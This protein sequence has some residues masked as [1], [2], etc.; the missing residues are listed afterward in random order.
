MYNPFD[1]NIDELI[2]DD[3]YSLVENQVKEGFYVEFKSDFQKNKDIAKS[4]ASFANTRGGWY[5]IGVEDYDKTN[6]AKDIVGFD[7]KKH[8]Q[9]KESIRQIVRTNIHPIPFFEMEL[10]ESNDDKYVLVIFIPES[11]ETPHILSNGVIYLRNGEESS[12]IEISDKYTLDKLYQKNSFLEAKLNS[13]LKNPFGSPFDEKNAKLPF[14]NLC[15]LPKNFN[16]VEIKDFYDKLFLD[17]FREMINQNESLFSDNQNITFNINF[18]NV[19]RTPHSIIFRDVSNGISSFNQTYEFFYNGAARLKIPIRFTTSQMLFSSDGS[20]NS[21]S[22]LLKEYLGEKFRE[23]RYVDI[24]AFYYIIRYATKKYSNFLEENVNYRD[25]VLAMFEMENIFQLVPYVE[26]QSFKDHLETYHVPMS[27]Y[28]YKKV[29]DELS[30]K[31]WIEYE[32]LSS[33]DFDVTAFFLN[34]LGLPEDT[35]LLPQAVYLYT[36]KHGNNTVL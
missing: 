31:R 11:F 22:N 3:L 2:F 17:R 14:L 19:A 10:L 20:Q 32:N 6:I 35:P 30:T 25:N 9:P 12:P 5:I 24:G 13:L 29:P 8:N 26:C 1:K 4:I 23:Y 7:I 28:E 36:K 18:K 15:L 27:T 16:N 33:L 34:C 21:Y